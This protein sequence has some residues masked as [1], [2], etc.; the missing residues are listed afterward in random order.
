MQEHQLA[1][2]P[3]LVT[4]LFNLADQ[5]VLIA[6]ALALSSGT[7][8]S[9]FQWAIQALQMR[10]AEPVRKVIAFLS[11]W[12]NP[13]SNLVPED[14]KQASLREGQAASKDIAVMSS[15]LLSAGWQCSFIAE[16]TRKVVSIR[17]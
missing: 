4:A 9:L 10:E 2:S 13:L 17:A 15:L 3:D 6:P 11:H 5:C 14:N 16:Y 1:A 12:A 8:P 7:L